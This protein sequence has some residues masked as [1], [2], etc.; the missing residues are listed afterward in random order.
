[1]DVLEFKELFCN[2]IATELVLP[3]EEVEIFLS[4]RLCLKHVLLDGAP[5]TG[6]T[7]LSKT[8]GNLS[9]GYRR[10]QMTPDMTPAD[11]IGYEVYKPGSE[12]LSEFKKG[13]VFSDFLLV[14]EIN[15][16]MPRTQSAL[17]EAMEER[18]ISISGV[19]HLLSEKFLVV[20]TRNPFDMDGT[21][22]LPASQRDRFGV[23]LYFK[24]A[25]GAD[26]TSILKFGVEK[27]ENN[28]ELKTLDFP[29]NKPWLNLSVSEDWYRISE[30]LQNFFVNNKED[31]FVPVSV[32]AYSTWL[33]MSRCLSYL[34]KQEHLSMSCLRDLIVPVFLHRMEP[35][36]AENREEKLLNIFDKI[37]GKV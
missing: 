29:T 32:R 8:L 33:E 10:I 18:K 13:P 34:R 16:A 22:L 4:A 12:N 19:D 30:E 2:K 27:P 15:R 24:L 9:G 1:M 11:I 5:G 6:K 28:S 26:L 36:G 20:A 35:F 25:Q 23:C 14:D 7:T 37:I 17:L 21:Y 31:G 3:I